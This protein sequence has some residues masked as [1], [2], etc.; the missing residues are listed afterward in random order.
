METRAAA[1]R[2]IGE[3]IIS[4]CAPAF[5]VSPPDGR[6]DGPPPYGFFHADRR[7]LSRLVVRVDGED[8][9]PA[10]DPG[11]RLGTGTARFRAHPVAAPGLVVE[12]VRCADELVETINVRNPGVAPRRAEIGLDLGCD[13]LD[14]AQVRSGAT[15]EAEIA[16]TLELG[17]LVWR[18]TDA[19]VTASFDPAPPPTGLTWTLDLPPGGSRTL[20]VALAVEHAAPPPV[21][22]PTDPAPWTRPKLVGGDPRLDDFVRHGLD[23]L[24][25]LTLAPAGHPADA[26]VGAGSPWYLTLFGRDSLWTARMLLPL[27]TGVAAS[28]LRALAR[29][30][31]TVHDP[32]TEEE[33][34][35]I[36]HELRHA[37]SDHG[38]GLVLPPVYYGAIDTTPLFVC[39][40][41]DA[42]RWGLPP[43]S[44]PMDAVRRALAWTRRHTDFLRYARRHDG[45]LVNQGWKD[46][47]EAV[48]F[49]D[50][51]LA[52]APIALAE[53]QAYA[54]EAATGG[55]ALLRAF[56][57]VDADA[58]AEA[59]ELEVWAAGLR[60]RF[61]EHFRLPDGRVALA[62]DADLRPVDAVASN[63]GHVLGTGILDPS[64]EEQVAR[65]LAAPDMCSGWGL[66]TLAD[67]DAG[68]DALGYHIGAVWPHDTAIAVW[69]MARSGQAGPAVRLMDGLLS[70]ASHFAYEL[71]ELWSG[72]ARRAG[73][74]PETYPA[75]CRPQAWAAAASVLC[76]RALLGLEP[77][78]PH[79]TVT[80]RPL[81]G[82]AP[83]GLDVDGLSI[84]GRRVRIGIGR[85]GRPE[86]VGLPA[87]LT[88]STAG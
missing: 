82:A 65:W 55:A 23:Q 20:R 47:P 42:W 9:G 28:T 37:E 67:T 3:S 87:G 73:R 81:A 76:L 8:L 54:Y 30:Q 48:R 85:T 22:R 29:R 13:L 41:V 38:N 51:A 2:L 35:K 1:E 10:L 69:G 36:L 75:A 52:R 53:V 32:R 11:E 4:V 16:A 45:G 71:P 44:L 33:P 49:A 62:L 19:T 88:V 39:L 40:A 43:G 78:V 46:S 24:A 7:I 80:V 68:F 64:Q 26:F 74:G 83:S 79:G 70:A 77:D 15:G 17:R 63:M 84:A 18:G 12:R 25:A 27:G 6:L 21:V 50:G 56:A 34:G 61:Q 60:R 59:R 31:G 66:R 57:D 5:V 58:D 14:V 86:V 72:A